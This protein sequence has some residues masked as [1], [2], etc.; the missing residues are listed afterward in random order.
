VAEGQNQDWATDCAAIIPC[1]NESASLTEVVRGTL[2]HLPMVL[3]VDDG[4]SD[5]TGDCAA[6][7]G[8]KVLRHVSNLGK[9]QALRTGFEYCRA[10]GYTW[11]L[12]LDGDGQHAPEDIPK[13]FERARSTGAV[14]VVGDRFGDAGK[15]PWLRR[16]VNRWMTL[17]LSRLT[18]RKLADSQCGFRLINLTALSHLKLATSHFETESELLVQFLRAGL[19]VEFVPVQVIYRSGKSEI[20]PLVDTWRWLRWWFAQRNV[21]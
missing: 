11:A 9:G 7:A 17:R 20:R 1:L 12:T 2:T 16:N 10:H 19:K 13:F 14:L 5:S 4:S 18:G 8:A 15:M 6:R 21:G 3:V